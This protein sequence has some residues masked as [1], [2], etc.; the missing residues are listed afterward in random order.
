MAVRVNPTWN[1]WRS[2]VQT[3]LR[4]TSGFVCIL[5]IQVYNHSQ[6]AF[7]CRLAVLGY[8]QLFCWSI[9]SC[10]LSPPI[11]LL[12]QSLQ[13]S[14][15][16]RLIFLVTGTKQFYHAVHHAIGIVRN[17]TKQIFG[18]DSENFDKPAQCFKL[19]KTLAILNIHN[20]ALSDAHL[21]C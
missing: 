21:F 8:R 7:S 15:N 20:L 6:A 16:K 4:K 1:R 10:E 2:S 12:N 9:I 13:R 17:R 5:S 14:I 19:G 18:R 3:V 11:Q